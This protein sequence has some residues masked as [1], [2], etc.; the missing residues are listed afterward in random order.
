MPGLRRAATLRTLAAFALTLLLAGSSCSAAEPAVSTNTEAAGSARTGLDDLASPATDGTAPSGPNIV[1]ITTD[2][3]TLDDLKWM[4]QTRQLIGDAGVTFTDGLSPHPLCCPA[5]AEILTG[6]YAQNNGV[7]TNAGPEGG[8]RA[9]RSPDNT[10]AA[11]LA[12]GGYR[13]AFFGKF[14]NGYKASTARPAGWMRWDP[15]VRGLYAYYDFVQYNNGDPTRVRG[16]HVS[17]YVTGEVV[18]TIRE[19]ARPADSEVVDGGDVAEAAPFFV[20]ASYVA[21]HGACAPRNEVSCWSSPLPAERHVRARV[22]GDNP[23]LSKPSF[24]ERDMRDKPQS[25]RRKPRVDAAEMR[26]HF[27][28]RIRSLLSVDDGVRDIITTLEQAGELDNTLVVFTSDNGYLTGE[29]RHYGKIVPYEEALRVPLLARGPGVIAGGT[30]RTQATLIDLTATFMAAAGVQPGRVL[31]GVDLGPLMD[32]RP[33]ATGRGRTGSRTVLIQGGAGQAG[34]GWA[35]RGVRTPRY[36][37]VRHSSGA[38]ELY[39]R[40]RDPWQ[41]RSVHAKAPYRAVKRKLAKAT[42][43]LG[44]C[45]GSR[46]QSGWTVR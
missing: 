20:W 23:A 11:W 10:V 3:Q 29:H 45:E 37:Y 44:R 33:L 28:Q 9:L 17:D 38:V 7:R 32:E 41:L 22:R 24:N 18:R 21:P 30:V 4:P 13:T 43:R 19:W 14:L 1:L 42:R 46:C 27:Q 8:Y 25:M 15:T 16:T 31:D 36:T 34:R 5:R 2:D 39:D 40:D 12:R 35:Y 6:Q 26:H